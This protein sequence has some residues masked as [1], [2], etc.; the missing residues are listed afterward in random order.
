M[1]NAI[2]T[3]PL[4]PATGYSGVYTNSKE[5]QTRRGWELTLNGTPVKNS[6]WQWDLGI[7]WSTYATYY[8]KLDSVYSQKDPWVKVGNRVDAL[9]SKD[10]VKDP[11][12]GELIFSSSGRLQYS[13]YKSNF[14]WTDPDFVWGVNTSIRYKTFSLFMS[15]DG[16]VGG[17]MN[18]RTESYMWQSGIHPNSVTPERALDVANP[19]SENF[20]GQGLKVVSGTATYDAFGNITSDTR[21]FAANDVYTTYKQYI[22]DLHNS[23]AWGGNGSPADTYSKTFLKLREISLTYNV[24]DNILHGIGKAASVS[25]VGQ[26]VLFWA[27]QF[28]YSDPDG[29]VEDF[30]DPSVRYLGFNVKVS[31]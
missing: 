3:G 31:F 2:I 29:G 6:D 30:A 16:V 21:V 9:V 19:G 25:L 15:F 22:I 18:T 26:N 4:S 1:Y 7:N 12:T 8:T 23:S 11:K 13:A 17:L 10:F 27:K 14:G 28:K 5:E 20:L 24:P